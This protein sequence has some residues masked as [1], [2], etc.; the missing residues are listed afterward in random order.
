[1]RILH[2]ADWH[3]ADRLGRIDRTDD[4]RRAV[5]RVA[6]YCRQENA[7][8]LLVAGD[9]LREL[10]GADALPDTTRH[11]KEGFAA[12]L[13]DGGTIVTRTGNQDKENFCQPLPHPI[14]LA[15]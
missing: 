1:M 15:D 10:A 13:R 14:S 2:T 7:D 11:F 6:D 9:L 3:L 8:V 4:L 12:F 5:E